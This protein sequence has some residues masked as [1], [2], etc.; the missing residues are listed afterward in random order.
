M[1][2]KEREKARSGGNSVGLSVICEQEINSHVPM[3]AVKAECCRA[4][5][6]PSTSTSPP[7]SPPLLVLP[8]I[9]CRVPIHATSPSPS[10]ASVLANKLFNRQVSGIALPKT[11]F[12]TKKDADNPAPSA[13]LEVKCDDWHSRKNNDSRD[14]EMVS[15]ETNKRYVRSFFEEIKA[16][17]LSEGER[18]IGNEVK[19]RYAAW[20]HSLMPSVAKSSRVRY[21]DGK[22][23]TKVMRA[24]DA[25]CD[26]EKRRQKED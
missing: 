7:L 4:A 25:D 3:V 6:P 16:D 12:A 26:D 24:V 9:N 23:S 22:S 5:T 14:F 1:N 13:V 19:E 21:F 20:T 11:D 15:K 8:P 2:T 18:A 10:A 17:E